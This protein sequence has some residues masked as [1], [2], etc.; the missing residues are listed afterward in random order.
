LIAA[1]A[2]GDGDATWSCA[3]LPLG[4]GLVAT[5][6]GV[7][8][9][10]APATALLLEGFA[11]FDDGVAGERVTPTGA[12]I[13]RHLGAQAAPPP[14]PRRLCASGIGFGTR[15]LPDRSNVLRVLVSMC[16][17]AAPDGPG[18][19]TVAAIGFEIDDQT[20]ED[21]AAGLDRIRTVPGVLDVLQIP[22]FGKKGRMAAHIQVLTLPGALE[23][24][25]EACFRETS[26]IGLRTQLLAGRV[27]ARTTQAVSVAGR[28]VRVKRVA[29]PG[30][31]TGKAESDDLRHADGHAARSRLRRTAETIAD[32]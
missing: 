23:A 20:A 15:T 6:H 7:L 13:L 26:T 27:L 10:P 8:P 11:T 32:D 14:G 4:G 9:V 30:G 28:D 21:L 16:G 31:A 17:T 2:D 5:V 24:T 18:H 22:A 25:V 19:R 12:A 1:Q 29:R 3:P